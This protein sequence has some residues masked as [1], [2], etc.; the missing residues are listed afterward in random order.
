MELSN[1]ESK[2]RDLITYELGVI[3]TAVELEQREAILVE[4]PERLFAKQR[5]TLEEAEEKLTELLGRK[6]TINL[7]D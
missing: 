7:I 2:V 6:T 4:F 3:P 5:L 1:K